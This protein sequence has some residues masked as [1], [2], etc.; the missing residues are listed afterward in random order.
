MMDF[1]VSVPKNL[2]AGKN[3]LNIWDE[4]QRRS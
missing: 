2:I 1:A 3:K 4:T